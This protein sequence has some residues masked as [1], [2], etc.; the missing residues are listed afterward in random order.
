MNPTPQLSD[1]E[2]ELLTKDFE[3]YYF[4]DWLSITLPDAE[5]DYLR[6]QPVALIKELYTDIYALAWEMYRWQ[7]GK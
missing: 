5:Y 4:H 7:N 1:E 6:D 3:S 2:L